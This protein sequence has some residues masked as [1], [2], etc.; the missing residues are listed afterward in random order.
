[1]DAGHHTLTC[2]ACGAPLSKLKSLPVA[3]PVTRAAVTHQPHTHKN[4]KRAKPPKKSSFKYK[5]RRKGFW[6]KFAEEA[7]DLVEDIFD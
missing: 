3:A 4:R 5:K 1:M 2:Q 6:R 7:F